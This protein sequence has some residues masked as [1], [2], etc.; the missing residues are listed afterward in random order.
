M[1][2]IGNTP[3]VGFGKMTARPILQNHSL[4]YEFKFH[5]GLLNRDYSHNKNLC[6]QQGLM[7]GTALV[8][9]NGRQ[10]N[11]LKGTSTAA[12]YRRATVDEFRQIRTLAEKLDISGLKE[13]FSR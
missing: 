7:S 3:R 10:L 12:K 13:L 5:N 9:K 6:Y 4:I 11:V 8:E 2:M 1:M